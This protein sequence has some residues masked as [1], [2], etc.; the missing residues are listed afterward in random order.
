MTIIRARFVP[1]Y[2]P[3]GR[4]PGF[5]TL[6]DFM[7]SDQIG[8]PLVKAA[9]DIVAV[10]KAIAPRSDDPRRPARGAHYSDSFSIQAG[11]LE[12]LVFDSRVGQLNRHRMV[13]IS[14]HATDAVAVEF[15]TGRKSMGETRGAERRAKQGGWN[16]PM[17]VLGRAGRT[18]GRAAEDGS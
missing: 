4:S 6:G 13:Q 2:K 1:S 18:V 17:R 9:I 12:T 3:K 5:G 7:V 16:K 15:G 14:N 11:P 10:A 8:V